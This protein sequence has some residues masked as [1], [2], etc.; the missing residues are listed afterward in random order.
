M[1]KQHSVAFAL[2]CFISVTAFAKK[3]V[4]SITINSSDEIE[5]AK[6]TLSS[7]DFNFV[8][9]VK[10]ND[11]SWFK[12][13]CLSKVQCDVLLVSGHFGG[14]FFGE[15]GSSLSLSELEQASCN[16][17]C[18]G[19]LKAPKDVFLFG[20]NTLA[21]K[22]EDH[23]TPEQYM[24]VLM[25]DGFTLAQAQQVVAFRYSPIGGTFSNRMTHV[26]N[27]SP[28]IYGFNSVSPLGKYTGPLFKKHLQSVSSTYANDLDSNDIKNNQKLL[29][30]F[31]KTS[32]VQE[33]G[34]QLTSDETSPVCFLST[35]NKSQSRID[36][37]I[38]IA[39]SFEKSANLEN[40]FYISEFLQKEK[41]AKKWNSDEKEILERITNNS[42]LKEQLE[43][44]INS[45]KS[46]LQ[47]TRAEALQLYKQIGW[48]SNTDYNTKVTHVLKLN[49]KPFT[50]E[51]MVFICSLHIQADLNL[52]D[53]T[54]VDWQN[55]NF[56]YAVS[57]LNSQ[58]PAIWKKLE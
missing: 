7:E 5:A 28:R 33:H 10:A 42:A 2:A 16:S 3:T 55:Q 38:W 32:M 34:K 39:E 44:I 26:F 13:A 40:A 46:W 51:N 41:W 6:Q 49:Q 30:I 18:N 57:C 31:S 48:A 19:I 50:Y 53:L 15:S 54:E 52:S 35:E 21:G 20:C 24:Q 8:E 17:D 37:L 4:C 23:R 45:E 56:K 12:N 36:K 47:R 29:S 43:L 27:K 22:N 14:T 25:N 9:L 1:T 11:S 58:N